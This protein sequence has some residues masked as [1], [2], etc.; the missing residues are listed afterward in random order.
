[1]R[2]EKEK[3]VAGKIYNPVV[4][5]L[6]KEGREDRRGIWKPRLE[7]LISNKCGN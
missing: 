1:M 5:E 7:K 4:P 3:M 2:I 6:L